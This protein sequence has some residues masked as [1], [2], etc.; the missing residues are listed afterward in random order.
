MSRY[1]VEVLPGAD[2]QLEKVKDRVLKTRL[3][4]AIYELGDDPRPNGSL[5]LVGEVDQWRIRV[6]DW[7]IV[8]RIADGRLVVVVV[9]VAPRGGAYG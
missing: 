3:L 9:R 8:Y 4:R 2:K 5:K 7:Q 6:G 1:R